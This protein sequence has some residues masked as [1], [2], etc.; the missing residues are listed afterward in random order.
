KFSINRNCSKVTVIG[1]RIRGVP[2]VM[3]R[4]LRVLNQNSIRVY[5]TADSHA[6]ISVLV[7]TEDAKKAVVVLHDEFKL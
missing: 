6:T 3:A 7:K 1:N 5:Q 2:G 4:I